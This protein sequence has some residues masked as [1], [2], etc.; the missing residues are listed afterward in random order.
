MADATAREMR[1][2]AE[3]V[4]ST[5]LFDADGTLLDF[6]KAETAALR[7]AFAAHGFPLDVRIAA[8]YREIN[9]GLWSDFEQG[10]I[11]KPEILR[12][13]FTQLFAEL[14]I[15]YDG[16]AFNDEYLRYMGEGFY[17]VDG[18]EEICRALAPH[19]SLYFATN[20]NVRTQL[21]RIAGSGLEKY[22][23]GTFVSEAAGAPKPSP[24]FFEY[25]FSRIPHLDKGRTIIVG[26]SLY[27][28][29]KGGRDAG[30]F[31]CWFNPLGKPCGDVRPDYEIRTLD[32]LRGIILGG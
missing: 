29:I 24:I 18:A 11:E 31:T 20:G 27:S 13:R 14:G 2:D 7:K 25:C 1:G 28:D 15:D 4:Y 22:F 17:T 3:P 23:L 19:C 8:R 26:D 30:I 5:V 6:S 12:R 32:A 16:I 9:N 10:R 21:S